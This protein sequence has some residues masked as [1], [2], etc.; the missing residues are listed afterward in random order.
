MAVQLLKNYIAT[1]FDQVPYHP[2]LLLFKSLLQTSFSSNKLLFFPPTSVFL[3]LS[4]VQIGRFFHWRYLHF[5]I[6]QFFFPSPLLVGRFFIDWSF[7]RFTSPVFLIRWG[8]FS[9]VIWPFETYQLL[10]GARMFSVVSQ[11]SFP[12]FFIGLGGF[13]LGSHFFLTIPRST[14]LV[15]KEKGNCNNVT[16]ERRVF[17]AE[18]TW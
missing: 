7:V 10:Y 13:L 3:S 4:L 18:V 16:L 6:F 11:F 1:Y 15:S 2:S 8:G 14:K 9:S 5:M 12:V 17:E